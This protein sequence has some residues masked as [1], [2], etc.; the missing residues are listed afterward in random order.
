MNHKPFRL[1]DLDDSDLNDPNNG[2]ISVIDNRIRIKDAEKLGKQPV[3]TF[4]TFGR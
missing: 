3:S 2:Y 4:R 1:D